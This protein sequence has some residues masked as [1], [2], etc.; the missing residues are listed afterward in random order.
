MAATQFL[1]DLETP[2]VEGHNSAAVDLF[3]LRHAEKV[4]IAF[5]RAFGDLPE[6]S[7][8]LTKDQKEFVRQAIAGLAQ[9]NKIICVRLALFAEMMKGKAWTP[10]TLRE[11]GGTE[12][13]G[14]TFLEETFSASAAP[15]EHRYHQRAARKVLQALLPQSHAVIKGNM[16]SYEELLE[17]SGYANRPKDFAGL[18]RVLDG[19]LR[20]IT[21]SDPEG[22]TDDEGPLTTHHSPLTTSPFTPRYYQLTHDYLVPS[23]RDW[24]TR[25]QAETRRG[26]AEL[27][28]AER[29]AQWNNKRESRQLPSFWEWADIILFTRRKTWNEAQQKM[30]QK[31]NRYHALRV[32]LVGVAAIACVF[33]GLQFFR[34]KESYATLM[35]N[36]LVDVD[37]DQ[38]PL[39]V[40]VLEAERRWADPK[41]TEITSSPASTAKAKL[42]AS[43]ALLPVDASQVEPLCARLLDAPPSEA[44]VITRMLIDYG[45]IDRGL[46]ILQAELDK[47]PA[48]DSGEDAKEALAKRRANAAVALARM[49]QGEPVY[50][51]LKHSADPRIRSYIISWLNTDGTETHSLIERLTV[52]KDISCRRALL[53]S[54]GGCPV[55]QLDPSDRDALLP[56]LLDW[57]ATATDAGF[58]AATEWLLRQWGQQ[59]KLDEIN[60]GLRNKKEDKLERIRSDVLKQA[61]KSSALWYVNGQGQTVVVLPGPSEFMMGSP[62]SEAGRAPAEQLHRRRIDRTFGLAAKPVTVAQFRRFIASNPQVSKEF[63]PAGNAAYLKQYC[64]EDDCPIILVSW[65]MAAAYCNWLSQE[66]GLPEAEWCYDKNM[67][68]KFEDGMKLKGNYLSRSGYRLPTEAEW[69]Y[70]C[71]AGATTSRY[72]GESDQLLPKYAWYQG[73]GTDRT[74]PAGRLKPNDFGLFDMHGNVYVWC[75]DPDVAYPDGDGGKVFGDR[76]YTDLLIQGGQNRRV[77]GGAWDAQPAAVRSAYRAQD[78]PADRGPN[79][80]FRVARTIR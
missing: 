54:L 11:V 24:L 13:I 7:S 50:P 37:I 16:R 46:P 45:Q 25:K 53:L 56:Q 23:I 61:D 19:D 21:P 26:R 44:G 69:E 39:M 40:R 71:R 48:P 73:S 14:V 70:A 31:A 59:E 60:Q 30:M 15:P 3:P 68:G 63:D 8:D 9:E 27:R 66:E 1:R 10:A 20:L 65:F 58:H 28:L 32:L 4:L 80:G 34:Q 41:L 52:E 72:Y 36:R 42:H 29:A 62:P 49:G 79:V 78:T 51:L 38:L 35:V 22:M 76:E 17:A 5:G 12:G 67:N 75:Q 64:P 33:G 47:Q 55:A 74:Q 43:L 18:L 2:L 57:Y 77:R 6:K